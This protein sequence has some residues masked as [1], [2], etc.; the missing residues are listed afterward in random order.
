MNISCAGDSSMACGSAQYSIVYE[1]T[2]MFLVK[3]WHI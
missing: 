3:F 1:A 2:N